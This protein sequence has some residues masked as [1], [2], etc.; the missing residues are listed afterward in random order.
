MRRIPV[1]R[2][3]DLNE[4]KESY[5]APS[6]SFAKL[7]KY[8]KEYARILETDG[9]PNND[10]AS[11]KLFYLDEEDEEIVISTNLELFEAIMSLHRSP[12]SKENSWTLETEEPET[13]KDYSKQLDNKYVLRMR[14]TVEHKLQNKT[15]TPAFT[16]FPPMFDKMSQ[17]PMHHESSTKLPT[18][19]VVIDTIFSIVANFLD[20]F[21]QSQ[22]GRNKVYSTTKD[23]AKIPPP[24]FTTVGKDHSSFNTDFVH[25]RHSC[26]NCRIKPIIGYRY[27]STTKPNYDLCHQCFSEKCDKGM[28]DED[29]TS[30]QL[31]QHSK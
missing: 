31:A 13:S 22:N 28:S 19:V 18:G 17:I 24:E 16:S 29:L 5:L 10:T 4:E 12:K 15:A 1:E 6:L 23:F 27:H 14:A 30:F 20:T 9:T 2:I 8:V 25:G 21:H 26:D 11:I 7:I 3:V